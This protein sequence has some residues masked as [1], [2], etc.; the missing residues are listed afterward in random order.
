MQLQAWILVTCQSPYKN[1]LNA[2]QRLPFSQIILLYKCIFFCLVF[3][4][5]CYDWGMDDVCHLDT[6]S[7]L[8]IRPIDPTE[9]Q[10]KPD[11]VVKGYKQTKQQ[12]KKNIRNITRFEQTWQHVSMSKPELVKKNLLENKNKKPN[13]KSNWD[14]N[15]FWWQQGQQHTA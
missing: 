5:F 13:N 8:P 3:S 4:Y 7:C 2:D 10:N 6:L 1:E 12:Q 14:A 9:I 15:T 11:N